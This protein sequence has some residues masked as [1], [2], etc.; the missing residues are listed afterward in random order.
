MG[1]ECNFCNIVFMEDFKKEFMQGHQ[2]SISHW[3]NTMSILSMYRFP[4]I[5]K[6]GYSAYIS[7][8]SSRHK[9]ANPG[10]K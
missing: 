3:K 9:E 10:G 6:S 4:G 8:R 2:N 1:Q 5:S 7:D